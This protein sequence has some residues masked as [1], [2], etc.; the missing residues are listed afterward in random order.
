MMY[1]NSIDALFE[2]LGKETMEIMIILYHAIENTDT[3]IFLH[4][5]DQTIFSS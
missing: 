5:N 4:Y 3:D 1:H 2:I